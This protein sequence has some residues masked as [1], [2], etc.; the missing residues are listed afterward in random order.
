MKKK[1]FILTALFIAIFAIGNN[2][3][4]AQESENQKNKSNGIVEILSVNIPDS[5][6]FRPAEGQVFKSGTISVFLISDTTIV[7]SEDLVILG[8]IVLITENGKTIYTFDNKCKLYA[9]GFEIPEDFET[10]KIQFIVEGKTMYY[11][12]IEDEWE[13]TLEP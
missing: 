6:V 12:L 7:F 11:N 1:I 10:K 5:I 4:L 8:E 9:K 2:R 13:S 3:A